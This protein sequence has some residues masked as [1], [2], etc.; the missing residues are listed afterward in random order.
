V[1]EER[2]RAER[3]AELFRAVEVL[4]LDHLARALARLPP[5]QAD[6]LIAGLRALVDLAAPGSDEP[7]EG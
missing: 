7:Q 6:D 4:G 2:A 1:S 5:G 3:F